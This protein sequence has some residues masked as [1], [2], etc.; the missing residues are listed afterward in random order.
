MAGVG[1]LVTCP[2]A[3]VFPFPRFEVGYSVEER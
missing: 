1:K 2:I 3:D